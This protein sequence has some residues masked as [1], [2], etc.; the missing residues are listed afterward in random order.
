MIRLAEA[1]SERVLVA[2]D[3]VL[4]AE[5]VQHE[6]EIRRRD[7]A[8]RLAAAAV[9]MPVARVQ[10]ERE[11]ASGAPFEGALFAVELDRRAAAPREHV[12]DLLEEVALRRG[13]STRRDLA[14]VHV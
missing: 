8:C 10:G 12:D 11:Q 9:E 3:E 4:I 14:D 5:H 6:R 2:P 13:L 1:A 7:E